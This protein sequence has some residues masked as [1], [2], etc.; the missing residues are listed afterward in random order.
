MKRFIW[1]CI[2]DLETETPKKDVMERI[3]DKLNRYFS[4]RWHLAVLDMDIGRWVVEAKASNIAYLKAVNA[5]GKHILIQPRADLASYFLLIDDLDVN[6]LFRHHK[7]AGGNW[8]PGRM[9]VETSGG[10]YQVWIRSFRPLALDEKRYWLKRLKSDP[11]A[12]PNDRWGRFPGFRNRKNHHRDTAGGYPLAKLVWIDWKNKAQIPYY[13]SISHDGSHLSPQPLGGDVCLKP[14]S[15]SVYERGDESATDFAYAIALFR[16]GYS[17][18]G[19]RDRILV[20]RR[21]WKNHA[22]QNRKRSY[23]DRTITR[24]KQIVQSS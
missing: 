24:A 23:I 17:S 13:L 4:N 16:R 6:L 10:N 8:K 12:D 18:E 14:I 5:N 9:I 1:T 2:Q 3:F 7:D 20:E 11:G 15:R 22:G 21:N 19:V